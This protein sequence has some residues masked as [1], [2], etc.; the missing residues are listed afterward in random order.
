MA[1]VDRV[2]RSPAAVAAS[3][4]L[5]RDIEAS[6]SGHD[7]HPDGT[8]YIPRDLATRDAVESYRRDGSHVAIVSETGSID[9]LR[10]R[11]RTDEK[12]LLIALVA[13]ALLWAI[14][15]RVPA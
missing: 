15:S 2:W 5:D 11:L 1:T 13:A 3:A 12:L 7:L 14:R 8:V 4:A 10:P 9:L 6:L